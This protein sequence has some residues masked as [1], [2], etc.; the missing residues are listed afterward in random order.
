M[1]AASPRDGDRLRDKLV[2][3]GGRSGT[4]HTHPHIHTHLSAAHL[5]AGQDR[6]KPLGTSHGCLPEQG[7]G[8][9]GHHVGPWATTLPPRVLP[10]W[11]RMPNDA[12]CGLTEAGCHWPAPSPGWAVG[13][14]PWEFCASP[15]Q[16]HS[17]PGPLHPWYPC[18]PHLGTDSRELKLQ[19]LIIYSKTNPTS[20]CNPGGRTDCAD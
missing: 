3:T 6:E 16:Q 18:S 10:P 2:T 11:L 19:K 7:G 1:A 13:Q 9:L 12:T 5:E 4:G 15:S 20:S 17:H 14:E 8:T